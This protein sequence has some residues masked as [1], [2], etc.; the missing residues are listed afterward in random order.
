MKISKMLIGGFLILAAI[1]I[2][3]PFIWMVASS[4]KMNADIFTA[5]PTVLIR[6]FYYENYVKLLRETSF[7]R[8]FLN[9]IGVASGTTIIGAFVC[10]MAGFAFAKYKFRGK[11]VLFSFILASVMVPQIVTAI[12]AFALMINIHWIN[13]YQAL[14]LPLTADAFGVFFMRTYISTVPGELLDAARMDGAHELIIF[15][16]IVIPIV[17]P[18]IGALAVFLF[19][20]QWIQYLWP[21][22]IVQTSTMFTLTLGL[23]ALYADVYTVDYGMLMAGAVL[24]TL[25]MIAFFVLTQKQFVVGLTQGAIKE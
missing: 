6:H 23:A 16:R 7:V 22:V 17:R 13:T 15:F 18:A 19:L 20:N 9:T 2:M 12:P 14:I 8:W 11:E 1:L 5:H 4:F 3:V 21:L 24:A 25:P 10:S